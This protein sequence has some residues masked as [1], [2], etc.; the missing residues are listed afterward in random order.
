MQRLNA[1]FVRTLQPGAKSLLELPERVIQFGEGNFLRGFTDWMLHELNKQGLF[2]GRVVL[3][4]PRG[5]FV[6]PKAEGLAEQINDQD[7]LYTV[8]LRGLEHGEDR[9][10]KDIIM[11]VS[12]CLNPYTDWQEVLKCA[13]NQE[14]KFVVSNTTEAGIVY[15]EQDSLAKYPPTSF[16][17]KLTAFLYHR[18]SYF[19]GDYTKGLVILPCELI[20]QNGENLKK[21]VLQLASE[22]GLPAEFITWLNEANDF[23]NTLVDRVVTGYPKDE[24]DDLAA[25]LGY[26]D[27]LVVAGELFHLWAIE[28]HKGIEQRL[29]FTQVGLNV[30]WTDDLT[31]YRTQKVRILNGAHTASCAVAFLYGLDTV[32]EMMNDQVLGQFVRET[33][34]DE[35]IPSI[36]ETDQETLNKFAD[37]VVERFRNPYIRHYLTS[38]MLNSTSK[39]KIRNLPSIQGY[40][41]TYGVYPEKLTFALAS[42]LSLYRNGKLEGVSLQLSRA[43]GNFVLNDNLQALTFLSEIWNQFTE[44]EDSALVLARNI[45]AN[46]QLWGQDLN[47]WP[48][49]AE[50]VGRY[51]YHIASEGL[52]SAIALTLNKKK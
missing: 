44:T 34:Y 48:G 51:L 10:K 42:L 40:Y 8:L 4:Q 38:I 14:I 5:H 29:P 36:T 12:R 35:I 20:E 37:A 24:I 13:E 16:P 22:G 33:I 32:G 39:F 2:N 23:L 46:D 52:E 41:Q 49:F 21:I 17:G 30:I 6:S 3:V 9:V 45:L 31:P 19:V 50:G 11:S 28:G 27:R 43:K 1:Q 47:C 7:G 26:E 25:E 18:F 15:D